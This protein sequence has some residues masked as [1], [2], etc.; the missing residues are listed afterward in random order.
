M[1]LIADDKPS[2]L[3]DEMAEK[4]DGGYM[5]HIPRSRAF[6]DVSA[7]DGAI[8]AVYSSS[9]PDDSTEGVLEDGQGGSLED[10]EGRNNEPINHT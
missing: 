7:E 8:I 4:P 1:T 10:L 6:T 9:Y 2:A 5:L 3:M